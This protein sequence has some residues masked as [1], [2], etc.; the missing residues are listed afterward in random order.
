MT[1]V[2]DAKLWQG[3]SMS[4]AVSH[5]ESEKTPVTA[6]DVEAPQGRCDSINVVS[7]PALRLVASLELAQRAATDAQIMAVATSVDTSFVRPW[8]DMPHRIL[9]VESGVPLALQWCAAL[10]LEGGRPFVFLSLQELQDG[11]AQL[12][13]EICVKR[14]GVTLIVEPDAKSGENEEVSA[15]GLAGIRQ[16]PHLAVIS[17]SDGSELQRMIAWCTTQKS[18]VL[19]WLPSTEVPAIR[20]NPCLP[21]EFG[22]AE[23]LGNGGDVAI[24]AWGPMVAAA[25]MAT[26]SLAEYGVEATVVNARFAQPL[27]RETIVH[28]VQRSLCTILVDEEVNH[29]GF[30]SWVLEHLLRA[31]ITQPVTVVAPDSRSS[32]QNPRDVLHQCALHIVE[33]CRWLT[34]PV[35]G[36]SDVP[37]ASTMPLE[38]AGSH[39]SRI[40]HGSSC[41]AIRDEYDDQRQVLAQQFSSFIEH[42]VAEYEKVG[43]RDLYLWRWCLHGLNLTTL[44]CVAPELRAHVCDT[45]LLSVILCVLLDDVADQ[46]GGSALLAALLEMACCGV[47]P[48]WQ[49]LNAIEKKHGEIARSVW[50]TYWSRIASYPQYVAFEPVL[51][52]DLSQFFN[53]MR[54]SHLVNGRPYLLNMAEHDL[55]TPHNMM[56]VSFATLDLMCSPGFPRADVGPLREAI[57]HA[58]CMGRIGNLLSTW[59]RELANHDFTSGVF[60]RAVI[61]GDLTLDE[62]EHGDVAQLEA[63]ICNGDHE[64]YFFHQWLEHRRCCHALARRLRCID[65]AKVL[66]GHDRFFAMHLGSRGQI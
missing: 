64:A 59:K 11:F 15:A 40:W 60:A 66:I 42:W 22:R 31:G 47:C 61:E 8:H 25:I 9:R 4:T 18:P 21:I 62:L 37:I 17:P 53:T 13:Q 45:K 14:A 19:I 16:L 52:Y 56:M 65:L 20:L 43:S 44:S 10:A 26:E 50:E 34:E 58:Q 54:Y 55:Y 57:W 12:H 36:L 39:A 29:G 6:H 1:N 30:S 63:V 46:H 28:A 35:N 24:V 3:L 38:T 32:R 2:T 5:L 7:N 33:H 48:S 51:R 41:A 49:D 27:D 23:Q